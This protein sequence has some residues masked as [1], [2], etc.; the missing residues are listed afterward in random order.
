MKWRGEKGGEVEISITPTLF[1]L[2]SD[3][4]GGFACDGA[5]GFAVL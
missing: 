5:F 4:Y 3:D 2:G 1:A